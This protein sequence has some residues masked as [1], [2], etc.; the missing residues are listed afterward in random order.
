MTGV[1]EV[2]VVKGLGTGEKHFPGLTLR[3]SNKVATLKTRGRSELLSL[4]LPSR[5]DPFP[6]PTRGW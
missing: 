5:P 6:T 2:V 3:G 4:L 1:H